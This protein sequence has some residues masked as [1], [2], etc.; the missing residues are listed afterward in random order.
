MLLWAI[1]NAVAGHIW[2]VGLYLPTPG[3]DEPQSFFGYIV[4]TKL[5]LVYFLL[6]HIMCTSVTGG[7]MMNRRHL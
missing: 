3:L 2:P 4:L 7:L 1:E 5:F 6:F